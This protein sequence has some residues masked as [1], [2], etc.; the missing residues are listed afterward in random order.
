MAHF[1]YA[2]FNHNFK[3]RIGIWPCGFDHNGELFCNQRYGDWPIK[4]PSKSS[5]D[6]WEE[7]EW[8]LLSYGKTVTASTEKKWQAQKKSTSADHQ[9]LKIDLKKIIT[10]NSIQVNLADEIEDVKIPENLSLF[11]TIEK[12]GARYIDDRTFPT[13]W[14]LEG[15]IDDENWFLIKDKSKSETSL[16][17]DF[18]V[19]EEGRKIMFVKL[20]VFEMPYGQS[21]CVSGLRIFGKDE[22]GELPSKVENV[23]VER[24]DP[25]TMTVEWQCKKAVGFEVLWGTKPDKLYHDYRVFG[26]N[27]QEIGA[28]VAG[29]HYYV[30]VDSFNER[31]IT[32]GDVIGVFD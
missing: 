26:K 31:G 17:H 3:R 30:R 9:W 11:S 18:V 4:I 25:L 29:S 5:K 28:L 15:N 12:Y 14:L 23:K 20:T 7:P 16:A 13:R 8:M 2:N 22:E 27:R 10:V 24:S 6:P 21:A 1:Y 19:I 32:H